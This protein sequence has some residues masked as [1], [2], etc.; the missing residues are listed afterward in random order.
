[1]SGSISCYVADSVDGLVK[2]TST[3]GIT[4]TFTQ[5]YVVSST[6]MRQICTDGKVIFGVTAGGP[7]YTLNNVVAIWDGGSAGASVTET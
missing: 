5:A 4:G 2:Y 7:L 1:M 3:T 6:R